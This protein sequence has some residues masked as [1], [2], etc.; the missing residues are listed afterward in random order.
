[1][2]KQNFKFVFCSVLLLGLWGALPAAA[3]TVTNFVWTNDADANWSVPA[4]WTNAAA[5]VSGGS[6]NYTLSFQ[7][8]ALV[9]STNNL[10][11]G[12]TTNGF[13]LNQLVFD[14]T[15][16]GVN[17]FGSNLVFMLG[18]SGA[19]PQLLQQ[20][21]NNM[22]INSGVILSNNFTFGGTGAGQ[23]TLLG[24]VSGAGNITNVNAANKVI[25]SG[26]GVSNSGSYFI[27]AGWLVFSNATTAFFRSNTLAAAAQTLN[28]AGGATGEFAVTSGTLALGSAKTNIISGS[29]VLLISGAGLVGLGEQGST[30]NRVAIKMGS[31]GLISILG[32]TLRNGGHQGGLWTDG[33]TWTNRADMFIASGA[34]NDLWDGNPEYIDAL[35]GSGVLTANSGSGSATITLGV[36]NGSG[37]F[38]GMIQNGTR[39][40]VVVKVGSGVQTFSGSNTFSGGLSV[41]AGSV[42]LAN[43]WAAQNSTVSNAVANGLA[44]SN[45]TAFILGGLSGAGAITLTNTAN[46]G[47]ALTVGN[48]NL[49]TTYSGA[50]GDNSRTGTLV[51]IGT[52]TLALSGTNTFMGGITL[53]NGTLS[54]FT[55]PALGTA[56]AALTN[57][58][59]GGNG[60]LQFNGAGIQVTNTRT[61]L[62]SGGATGTFDT[63]A[64][65]AT[66]FARI[67][68]GGTLAKSGSGT[69][70]LATNSTYSGGTVI[71]A[72]V[73]R[74]ANSNMN[75]TLFGPGWATNAL[76]APGN[77]TNLVVVAAG[78]TLDLNGNRIDQYTNYV[79]LAG[80]GTAANLGAL[81]NTGAID[82][83]GNGVRNVR[84]SANASIGQDTRRLDII[85]SID[86][87]SSFLTKLGN[88]GVG[89]SATAVTNLNG[90]FVNAGVLYATANNALGG[91]IVQVQNGASFQASGGRSLTN[92]IILDGGILNSDNNA[93]VLRGPVV[94]VA[95]TNTFTG[96]GN[97]AIGGAVTGPGGL[98]KINATTL[99]ITNASYTG[100]TVINAGAL[101]FVGPNGPSGLITI[102][103]GGVA[104]FLATGGMRFNTGTSAINYSTNGGA[105]AVSGPFSTVNGWLA[106]GLIN[107]A[108]D[109]ALAL[110]NSSSQDIDLNTGAG[111][112]K[113]SIGAMPGVTATYTGTLQP[114][115]TSYYVGGGGG[116]IIFS[117][118]NALT[119]VGATVNVGNGNGGTT[120]LTASNDA[121]GV[122]TIAGG[123]TLQLGANTANG[124]LA[125]PAI[126]INGQLI[127]NRSDVITNTAALS[128]PGNLTQAGSG[129]L[130][131][132]TPQAYDGVTAVSSNGTLVL[133]GSGMLGANGVSA[134]DFNIGNTA[135]QTASAL[136]DGAAAGWTGMALRVANTGNGVLTVSN[137]TLNAMTWFVMGQTGPVTG[138]FDMV[139]GTVNVNTLSQAPGVGNVQ[140]GANTG[141]NIFNL[142]GGTFTTFNGAQFRI[143]DGANTS[144]VNQ[145]GGL[146]N[147]AAGNLVVGNNASGN[148]TFNLSGGLLIATNVTRGNGMGVFN[149]NGGTLQAAGNHATWVSNLTNL[150]VLAG[151]AL[152]DSSNFVV[153]VTNNFAGVGALTKLGTGTLILTG[154]NSFTGGTTINA[155]LLQYGNSN[156]LAGAG[157]NLTNTAG[158]AVAF[159]FTNVQ[160]VLDSRYATNSAGAVALLATNANENI[161]FVALP[162]AFLGAAANLTYGG[163]LTPSLAEY[164]LGGGGAVLTFTNDIGAG[165]NITIGGAMGGSVVN[166]TGANLNDQSVTV[167]GGVL[168]ATDGAGLSTLA[169]L[170]LNG[171]IL[172]TSGSFLRDLG[173]AV[174]QVQLTNGVSGFSAFGDPAVINLGGLGATQLWGGASFSPTVLVLN[175]TTANTN[176]TFVNGLDLGGSDRTINVNA[177]AAG[178]A[179][180]LSGAIH[181]SGGL[182]KGGGGTLILTAPGSYTGITTVNGGVLQVSGADDILPVGTALALANL[183]GATFSLNNQNQTIAGLTGGG[184]AGGNVQL[185]G[186]GTL[187][188]NNPGA[189]QFSGVIAGSGNLTKVGAGTLT[190]ANN[191]NSFTGLATIGQGTLALTNASL[192]GSVMVSNGA[193]LAVNGTIQ[194]GLIGRYF[195][196]GGGP[197]YTPFT[198]NSPNAL[199]SQFA[200]SNAAF[201]AATTIFGETFDPGRNDLASSMVPGAFAGTPWSSQ[202]GATGAKIVNQEAIWTGKF[203]APTSGRYVFACNADD[204]VGVWID[205]SFVVNRSAGGFNPT[206]NYGAVYLTAG[207]HDIVI[208]YGNGSGQFGMFIDVALPNG[209][210]NRLANSLLSYGTL[211]QIGSLSGEAGGT[212]AINNAYLTV[213]QTANS[214]FAGNIT[215]LAGDALTKLGTGTL[216]LSGTN[217]YGAG[218]LI[219]GGVLQF[220][221]TNA[222][223]VTG[224]VGILSNAAAA[225]D[226][227]GVQAALVASVDSNSAGT[228]AL[229]T[230]SAGETLDFSAG[231]A[232]LALASLGAAGPVAYTGSFTA[233]N[234]GLGGLY[235]LGGGG[236]ALLFSNA[237]VTPYSLTILPSNNVALGVAGANIL[238]GGLTLGAGSTLDLGGNSFAGAIGGSGT[239]TNSSGTLATLAFGQDNT[240]LTFGG[241][242]YGGNLGL[243]KYGSGTWTINNASYLGG[244]TGPLTLNGGTITSTASNGAPLGTGSLV[245]NVGTLNFNPAG[246]NVTVNLAAASD[247]GSTVTYGPGGSVLALNRGG[248][249][250]AILTLGNSGAGANS[251]LVR[252]GTGGALAIAPANGTGTNNLGFKEQVLVNGGVL[253]NNGIVSPSILGR[254]NDANNIL[255]FLGYDTV[256]GF[257]IASYGDTNFAAASATS[258]SVLTSAVTV[259]GS[260]LN[261]YALKVNNITLTLSNQLTIG[262]GSD[263]AGLI[264][265]GGTIAGPSNLNFGAAEG[266]IASSKVAGDNISAPISGTGGLTFYLGASSTLTLSGTNTYSGGTRIM[267]AGGR[268][269]VSQTNQIGAGD[270][271]VYGDYAVGGQFWINGAI[272][273]TNNLHISG[274]GSTIDSP[275]YGAIRMLNG[276]SISGDI[277]LMNDAR[278]GNSSAGALGTISGVMYGAGG[279]EIGGNMAGVLA[280]T[281]SNT[282]SGTTLVTKG[283]LRATDG[284]GLP[285][286]SL[287][288]LNGGNFETGVDFNRTIGDQAGQV[289]LQSGNSGFSANTNLGGSASAVVFSLN[290]VG[291]TIVWN[292]TTNF[293]PGALVL[294]DTT[295]NANLVLSNS[296][297]LNGATR[298]INVNLSPFSNFV[299]T[300][301]GTVLN[302]SNAAVAGITKGGIGVLVLAGSN[303]YNSTI[304]INAGV[305]RAENGVGLSPNG[306]IS[307]NGGVWQTS[308]NIISNTLGAQVGQVQLPGGNSGFSAFNTPLTLNLG[309]EN[310]TLVWQANVYFNPGALVLNGPSAN[311]NITLVNNLDLNSGAR[312]IRVDSV[313]TVNLVGGALAAATAAYM[314]SNIIN[315]T[316]GTASL[317]KDGFGTLILTGSNSFNG[318]VTI[319]AGILQINN[320]YALG[321]GNKTIQMNAGTVG[322]HQLWLDGSGGNIDLGP[323]FSFFTSY[324][325]SQGGGAVVNLAGTNSIAGNFTLTGGGGGTVIVVNDGLLTLSGNF[326]P[327]QTGR[328]LNLRGAGNG[329]LSGV[330]SDA[331]GSMPLLKDAGTGTWTLTS[332]NTFRGGTTV[333]AGTLVV[334]ND[335]AGVGLGSG[336]IAVSSNASLVLTGGRLGTGAMTL[337]QTA[338]LTVSNGVAGPGG[339]TVNNYGAFN[340]V[341]GMYTN[342]TNNITIGGG[343]GV[344]QLNISGGTLAMG[345]TSGVN[346]TVFYIG[347]G[348]NGTGVVNM[349]GGTLNI[350]RTTTGG[351]DPFGPEISIGYTGPGTFIV[352]GSTTTAQ[353]QQVKIANYNNGTGLLVISN[354][355]YFGQQVN[356]RFQVGNNQ[357][358]TGTVLVDGAT[359]DVNSDFRLGNG[360]GGSGV[361]IIT[362]NALVINSGPTVQLGSSGGAGYMNATGIVYQSS[363]TFSNFNHA[364]GIGGH[365]GISTNNVGVFN[366]S[367]GLYAGGNGAVSIGASAVGG[368][369]T[370]NISSGTFDAS[371]GVVT[372]GASSN[373]VGLINLTGG[374]LNAKQ[375][376]LIAATASNATAT[377]QVSGGQ[378]NIGS[379]GI[380]AGSTFGSTKSILLSGGTVGALA[381]W[382]STVDLTLT[383]SP[384][385]GAVTFDTTNNTIGLSGSLSGPGSLIKAGA[386]TLTLS[387]ANSYTGGTTINDGTL[388]LGADNTLPANQLMASASGTLDLNGYNQLLNNVDGYLGMVTNAGANRALTLSLNTTTQTFGGTLAGTADFNV[389]DIGKVSM[390]GASSPTYSGNVSIT[391]ATVLV[392]GTLTGGGLISVYNLGTLGGTGTLGNVQINAGGTY[393]PGNSPGTQLVANLTLNSG[394]LRSELVATNNHDLVIVSNALAFAPG[395]TNYLHLVLNTGFTP[396]R[397][398]TYLIVRNDGLQLWDGS[399]FFLDDTSIHSGLA[400]TNGMVFQALGESSSTNFFSIQ[401]DFNAL[402]SDGTAN[403]ILLTVIPEPTSVNL[404]VVFGAAYLLR[405]LQQ[406]KRRDLF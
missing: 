276:S 340:L 153:T 170:T 176:L 60:T 368:K 234:A 79:V 75:T 183:A 105:L 251:V 189:N 291:S 277:E 246:T 369:G 404:L 145:T 44:F 254:N 1:M 306:N 158:G 84:L 223:P 399:T 343:T 61:F 222:I 304:N 337:S 208:G 255:D 43:T 27:N 129:T 13:R 303:T 279:L 9:N 273:V 175:E 373:S 142:S 272:N 178:T 93:N 238:A 25:L 364:L 314:P 345:V 87:G 188:V 207:A 398:A 185:L 261:T 387:G 248:Y 30:T 139:G 98:T 360:L 187:T 54:I 367:G 100:A 257:V 6:T 326:A 47:V 57:F 391:N 67:L 121:S 51:K 160:A 307:I 329:V 101:Q 154:S 152:L 159:G 363:G 16:A 88:G 22:T 193:T 42:L 144:V 258:V 198:S 28:I 315:S 91:T 216:I 190:L 73:V 316:P 240:S 325:A 385:P 247:P 262:N 182:T 235:R 21:V 233:Y 69:L 68:G 217:S 370:L 26:G 36:D 327:D 375:L 384:G 267:G 351:S 41:L 141:S 332:N 357:G 82:L 299:S 290:G 245:M 356:A 7:N 263:P 15:S 312:T 77:G 80:A 205:G 232:N 161:S 253:T 168:R 406:R 395:T 278:I 179:A 311:T 405:R 108:S 53:S 201:T 298:T 116:T 124:W 376:N 388:R 354:G 134:A 320:S 126:V 371:N 313:P 339:L 137:G 56:N 35:N 103:N 136:V 379:S 59:F 195:S 265:N 122:A 112:A 192:A 2:K 324:N 65:N 156:A 250:N 128:G 380:T 226:F 244:I 149:F 397:D 191:T 353:V 333:S 211:A 164:K 130:V 323:G 52:G 49:N 225:F 294:N 3:Q 31:G 96:N 295:A 260:P 286:N 228:V 229:T 196:L 104:K 318:N 199:L 18:V 252:S 366:L 285:A 266:V 390:T 282:Y 335:G 66:N 381:N 280:L 227:L 29:G 110:T 309:G 310:Q 383:N 287:L 118:T 143:A 392:Q 166:L 157:A 194:Q 231:G 328:H 5:P 24:G 401:Y 288:V 97:L 271:Y 274:I 55:D 204:A 342:S 8:T 20:S 362:N 377:V 169:S 39:T 171:G 48:N 347:S 239:L 71:N 114:V 330:I 358:S 344:A 165:T 341:G 202:A 331:A 218:T 70:I 180:T 162:G 400:L 125:S 62:L 155:G 210:T 132:N 236:G 281:G 394:T 321:I 317:I 284:I 372:V 117:N 219:N 140:I 147:L 259:T 76:G 173:G 305:V 102:N 33:S 23:I 334:T 386:G 292:G 127:Y 220:A 361:L 78:G 119:G 221:S 111:Y 148:A 81:A 107:P 163:T 63:V 302:S 167:Q 115:G 135:R 403:D 241:I 352:S 270:I 301:A 17:L 186:A 181:G 94:L 151:G 19:T 359:L 99:Y 174:N 393:S 197:N 296:L 138:R 224:K 38:G 242:L 293:N 206:P 300:I 120:V 268:L 264:L 308:A 203:N 10:G 90:I 45:G 214:T 256:K 378:L 83:S 249:T 95:P 348:A 322:A 213:N 133:A 177:T 4:A 396:L 215:G 131:I 50:L 365:F 230:T 89:I 11:V 150:N 338:V 349:T 106:S 37:V 46:A 382:T 32:G 172:E 237:L 374:V 297:D 350:V 109:G 12:G 74:L 269:S 64:N 209:T 336:A 319:A 113:L 34:T 389:K 58:T 146:L 212:L 40:T 346:N 72:G 85:G 275:T 14:S 86:G 243:T 123:A 283:S 289:R 355:A 92:M 402:G 184:T 200:S